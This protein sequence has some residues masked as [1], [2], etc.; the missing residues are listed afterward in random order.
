MVDNLPTPNPSKFPDPIAT[1]AE[2]VAW[3]TRQLATV[4]P[5]CSI[6]ITPRVLSLILAAT[7]PPGESP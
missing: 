7:V 1:P 3:A 2:A 5:G 4:R 6:T